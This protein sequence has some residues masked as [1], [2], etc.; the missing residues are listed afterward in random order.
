VLLKLERKCKRCRMIGHQ[1]GQSK[2][3][4][5]ANN[6]ALTAQYSAT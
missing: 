2:L 1:G 5:R 4:Y 3:Q 6:A